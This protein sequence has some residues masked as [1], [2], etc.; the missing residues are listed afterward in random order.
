VCCEE[1]PRGFL[2]VV[3]A[4]VGGFALAELKRLP[5]LLLD[6][7]VCPHPER[8]KFRSLDYRCF[9]CHYF[10]EWEKTMDEED[11]RLTNEI[12]RIREN[13]EAYLRGELQ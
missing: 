12:D 7:V 9:Q 10:K 5:C 1:I 11:E 2:G 13:P 4:C 8:A 6:N 3:C